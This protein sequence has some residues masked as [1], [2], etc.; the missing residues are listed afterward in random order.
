M[1]ERELLAILMKEVAVGQAF[2]HYHSPHEAYGVIK[3]ELD[4][5]FEEVRRKHDQRDEEALFKEAIQVAATALRY[6]WELKE[7]LIGS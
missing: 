1:T 6:A 2:G 3:E 5:F 4:E 7:G